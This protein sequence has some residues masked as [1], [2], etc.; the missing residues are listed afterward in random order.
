[1]ES[2]ELQDLKYTLRA[3]AQAKGF[4]VTVV[5]TLALPEVSRRLPL[6]I[7]LVGVAGVLAFSVSGWPWD[8]L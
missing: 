5:V 1:M 8:S 4:A 7:A 6:A 3:L 2:I